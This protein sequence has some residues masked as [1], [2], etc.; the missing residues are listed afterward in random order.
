MV[1]PPGQSIGFVKSTRFVNDGKVELGKEEGLMGLSSRELLFGTKVGEIVMV[2][3]DFKGLRVTLK[4]MVEK[5]KGMDDSEEFLV[6]DIIVLF[7][8]LHC[9]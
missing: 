7:H 1:W 4:V 5:F 9:F 8:R 6:M 2:C 3:P